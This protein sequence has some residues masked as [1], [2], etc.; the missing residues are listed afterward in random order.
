MKPDNNGKRAL[1]IEQW[2]V[3]IAVLLFWAAVIMFL[4]TKC[5]P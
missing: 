4:T 2:W 1:I 5:S 3:G